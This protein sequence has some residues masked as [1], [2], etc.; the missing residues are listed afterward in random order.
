[1][2]HHVQRVWTDSFNIPRDQE[3]LNIPRDQEDRWRV[4]LDVEL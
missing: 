4:D 3:D 2:L 1:M